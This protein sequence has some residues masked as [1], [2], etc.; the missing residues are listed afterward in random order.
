MLALY[1]RS[2]V[3]QRVKTY[4]ISQAT[5]VQNAVTVLR[6]ANRSRQ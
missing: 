2:Q 4:V 5:A 6:R 1:I 3:K